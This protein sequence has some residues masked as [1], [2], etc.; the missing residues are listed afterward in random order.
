MEAYLIDNTIKFRPIKNKITYYDVSKK[1]FYN[2]GCYYTDREGEAVYSEKGIAE[3]NMQNPNNSTSKKQVEKLM[4]INRLMNVAK[5]LNEYWRPNWENY[6][7]Y[8]YYFAI[9][10]DNTL[11]I[12]FNFICN[13]SIVYFKSE[14][15]A[16]KAIEILGEDII[17]LALCTDW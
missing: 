6:E 3:I 14:E 11:I 12:T 17:R 16:K 2:R 7:Q 13:C 1:L 15:L 8:K 4:A 5:Y 10:N 9:S